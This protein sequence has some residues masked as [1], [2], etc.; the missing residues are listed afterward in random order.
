MVSVCEI[1]NASDQNSLYTVYYPMT[2]DQRVVFA[3]IH[4]AV[5]C[6]TPHSS[7]DALTRFY[8]LFAC[9]SIAIGIHLHTFVHI[10][11]LL[12]RLGVDASGAAEVRSARQCSTPSPAL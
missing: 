2:Y 10:Q 9:P 3:H 12:D 7:F 6:C 8:R 5:L 11:A 1:E 4:A